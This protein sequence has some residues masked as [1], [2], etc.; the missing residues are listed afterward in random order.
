MC[1]V[2]FSL[3]AGIALKTSE[4]RAMIVSDMQTCLHMDSPPSTAFAATPKAGHKVLSQPLPTHG[5]GS[6]M[7]GNPYLLG[8]CF[9]LSTRNFVRIKD[10]ADRTPDRLPDRSSSKFFQVRSQT[11]NA[12]GSISTRIRKRTSRST[13]VP[14]GPGQRSMIGSSTM[15][16]QS[17]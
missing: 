11:R 4:M 14:F 2:L 17:P 13:C 8:L 1:G 6:P 12:A 9:M 15:P 7:Q 10:A 3:A 5:I 16:N